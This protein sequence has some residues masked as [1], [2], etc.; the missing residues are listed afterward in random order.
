MVEGE[1]EEEAVAAENGV[2]V[3][4]EATIEETLIHRIKSL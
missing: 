1:A 4:V 2:E 3:V